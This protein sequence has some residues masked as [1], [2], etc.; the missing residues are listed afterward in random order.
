MTVDI[1]AE[2]RVV[3]IK[4]TKKALSDGKVRSV[5]IARDAEKR[6]TAPLIELCEKLGVTISYADTMKELGSVCGIDVGAAVVAL[7]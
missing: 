7:I 6:V 2:K 3:G 5:I 1:T 4:Q